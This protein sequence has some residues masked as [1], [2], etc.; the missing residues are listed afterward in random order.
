MKKLAL[1]F[2]LIPVLIFA[3][4]NEQKIEAP[5]SS[6]IVYLTGGEISHKKQI[7]LNPGRNELV[8]VGLSA[9]LIPKS[10]Q[11]TGTGDFALL[12]ISS[13]IDFL[14]GQKKS[15]VRIKQVQDSMIVMEDA[16][17]I[18]RGNIDAYN[19]EKNLLE[20]NR[21]VNGGT[22]GVSAA[23]LKATSDFYVQRLMEINA[24]VVKLSRKE[25]NQQ[26]IYDRL[27]MQYAALNQGDNPPM[28]EVTILVNNATA[29]KIISD[30]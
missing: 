17:A 13:R 3:G 9:H 15:D 1:F 4:E 14:Y 30:V 10:I 12:A 20:M 22:D 6:V 23:E 25:I 27:S 16:L 2:T 5:I 24:E 11:F 28:A 19:R 8:F 18:T 21:V 7:T 26:E 29:A